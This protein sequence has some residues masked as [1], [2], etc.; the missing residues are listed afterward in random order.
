VRAAATLLVVLG[1]LLALPAAALATDQVVVQPERA[2]ARTVSLTALGDPDVQGRDYTV[3]DGTGGRRVPIT[4]HSLDRVLDAAN[5]DPYRFGDVEV[6]GGGLSVIIS[7]DEV[8]RPDAFPDGPPVFWME[9]DGTS[10]FLRPGSDAGS[11]LQIGGDG[12]ITVSLSRPSRLEVTATASKRRI[13]VGEPVSFTATVDGAR[14]GEQVTVRWYFDDG[15]GRVA[16]TDVTHRF[17]RRNTYDVLVSATTSG[18]DP[19]D[20]AMVTVQV[21]RARAGPDR[22]GGGTNT[23]AN[24]PDSGSGTVTGGAGGNGSAGGGS[25]AA[26]DGDGSAGAEDGGSAG[27]EDGG[28]AGA[29]GG[30]AEAARDDAAAARRRAARTRAAARRRSEARAGRREEPDESIEAGASRGVSGIELAD[31]SALSSQAGRDAVQAARTG[32]LR[33][34]DEEGGGIPP[35]VWWSLGTAALLG[36]GGWREARSRP[37][38]HGPT[39]AADR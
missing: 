1:A 30:G 22:K 29:D 4:G 26:G 11:S 8:T 24:A 21:G 25:S 3:D 38:N 31:L 7:R 19:G 27:A 32:R 9:Q 37:A 33:E 36:L 15:G 6:T 34:E 13:K 23:D 28:P 10:R 35:G 39:N 17:R 16:G 18:D 20:D 12:P 14:E 2:N 5:V